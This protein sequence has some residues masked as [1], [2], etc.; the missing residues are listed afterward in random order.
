[1]LGSNWH[2]V[3]ST[4]FLWV[5]MVRL[6]IGDIDSN[7]IGTKASQLISE[8]IG[9]EF[10]STYCQSPFT[11]EETC[12]SPLPPSECYPYFVVFCC[13]IF[14]FFPSHFPIISTSTILSYKKDILGT[15]KE[16]SVAYLRRW[17]PQWSWFYPHFL[18]IPASVKENL[19]ITN[20]E[21]LKQELIWG[22]D[23]KKRRGCV[24]FPLPPFSPKL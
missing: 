14:L 11:M 4:F 9:L 10:S 7:S 22:K 12:L 17:I 23:R 2:D 24:F 21:R 8:H 19:E 1:M 5:E 20:K 3:A 18:K 16:R 15:S 13:I 6:P